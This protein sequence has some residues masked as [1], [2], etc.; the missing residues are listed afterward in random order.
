MFLRI[1]SRSWNIFA[2]HVASRILQ[3]SAKMLLL[4]VKLFFIK[5][6]KKFKKVVQNVSKRWSK[7]MPMRTPNPVFRESFFKFWNSHTNQV[8]K[9]PISSGRVTQLISAPWK[10]ITSRRRREGERE[11]GGARISILSAPTTGRFAQKLQILRGKQLILRYSISCM[12]S[13]CVGDTEIQ[14]L[15][16]VGH[17]V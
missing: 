16:K 13:P 4:P 10:V 5:K 9:T 8:L 7:T 14:M 2:R 15:C 17:L 6:T 1:I 11:R 3:R 12:K